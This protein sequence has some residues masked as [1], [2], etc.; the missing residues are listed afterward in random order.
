MNLKRS[1]AR[2]SILATIFQLREF[3]LIPQESQLGMLSYSVGKL[4]S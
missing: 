1:S 3:P 4:P 2:F